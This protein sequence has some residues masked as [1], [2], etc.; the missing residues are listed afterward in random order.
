M[1]VPPP[2]GP[3]PVIPFAQVNDENAGNI[4]NNGQKNIEDFTAIQTPTVANAY[5]VK[6]VQIKNSCSVKKSQILHPSKEAHVL[7]SN[8]P[9]IIVSDDKQVAMSSSMN[10]MGKIDISP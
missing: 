4:K 9:Y 10:D 3:S 2:N 5:D 8:L 1:D 7:T 6:G